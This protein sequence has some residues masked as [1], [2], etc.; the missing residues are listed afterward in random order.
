LTPYI[1]KI[2]QSK[3]GK[4]DIIDHSDGGVMVLYVPMMQ[5]DVT[6]LVDHAIALGRLFMVHIISLNLSEHMNTL[7]FKWQKNRLI[8]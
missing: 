3:G 5:S 1:L 2:A 7:P 4:V 8:A 6:A